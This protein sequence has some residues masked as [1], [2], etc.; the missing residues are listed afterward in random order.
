MT[1]PATLF[2]SGEIIAPGKYHSLLPP[3]SFRGAG[4]GAGAGVKLNLLRRWVR[5]CVA[6]L[7]GRREAGALGKG[8][9]GAGSLLSATPPSSSN[10]A[11]CH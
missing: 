9:R 1:P 7:E 6:S 3:F 8:G 4:A 5:A 10:S 2:S 11:V